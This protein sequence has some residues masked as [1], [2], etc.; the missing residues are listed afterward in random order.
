MERA[1]KTAVYCE[2][3]LSYSVVLHWLYLHKH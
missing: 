2:W 1:G 3:I